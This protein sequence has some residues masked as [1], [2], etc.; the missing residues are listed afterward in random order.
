MLKGTLLAAAVLTLTAAGTSA[1]ECVNGGIASH[2]DAG[3]CSCESAG[4]GFAQTP[5]PAQPGRAQT[6]LPGQPGWAKAPTH[7]RTRART[8]GQ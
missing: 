3:D 8:S 2:C 7:H 5:L 6:P 4:P 1:K